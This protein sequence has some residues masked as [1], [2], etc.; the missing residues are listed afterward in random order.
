MSC[1][2]EKKTWPKLSIKL[3]LILTPKLR[4]KQILLDLLQDKNE[5]S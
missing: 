4:L 3:A 2:K 5:A 1:I